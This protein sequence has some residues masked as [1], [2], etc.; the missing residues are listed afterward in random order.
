MGS[1][2]RNP[3]DVSPA[4]FRGLDTLFRPIRLVAE[5][6]TIE[7]IVIHEDMDIMLSFL[8]IH[9]TA[10]INAFLARL[11]QE[12]KKPFVLVLP[13]GSAESERIEAESQLLQ[14]GVPVFPTMARAAPGHRAGQ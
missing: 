6:P 10:D 2:L 1:I 14:A 11:R 7:I 12:C 9:E 4:Q 8:S 3:V 13:P 5:E